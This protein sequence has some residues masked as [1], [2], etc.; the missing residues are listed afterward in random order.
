MYKEKLQRLGYSID[1][2]EQ[3]LV[4][5]M[6][7]IRK[8][9]E[10]YHFSESNAKLHFVK[11]LKELTGLGLKESKQITDIYFDGKLPDLIIEDRRKKL[12]RLAKMP[13]IEEILKKIDSLTKD[14]FISRLKNIPLDDLF[15][16]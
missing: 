9:N 13:L 10:L 4:E 11:R 12:E 1:V 15:R 16:K 8:D 14:E 5:C 7:V 6:K 2:S 3:S